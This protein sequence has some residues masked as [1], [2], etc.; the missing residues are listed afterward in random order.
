MSIYSKGGIKEI[1]ESGSKVPSVHPTDTKVNPAFGSEQEVKFKEVCDLILI[2]LEKKFPDK[3]KLFL[4]GVVEQIITDLN[5]A[6]S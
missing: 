1:P 3:D 4:I 5:N 2:T 6:E